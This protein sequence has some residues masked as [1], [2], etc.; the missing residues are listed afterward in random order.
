MTDIESITLDAEDDIV[1][2][3]L[4]LPVGNGEN[5]AEYE[6]SFE[7]EGYSQLSNAATA[8][9][10]VLIDML[11]ARPDDLASRE[12]PCAT[13]TGNCCGRHFGAVRL[14]AH[15]VHRMRDAGIDVSSET[16]KFY[17]TEIFSG[18][19]GE[20]RLVEYDGPD[21][22]DDEECCPHLT[23]DGCSIYEHRPL[24]CRE[25]SAW[26]CDIYAEDEEKIAKKR[27]PVVSEGRDGVE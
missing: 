14:T 2:I 11:R 3:S 21:A 1:T 18:H 15:D 22:T 8:L 20:F 6:E 7:V 25:Y 16:V 27:L 19:V 26:T 12:P 13:C 23:R 4:V 24:V 9:A 5:V 10:R 17:K